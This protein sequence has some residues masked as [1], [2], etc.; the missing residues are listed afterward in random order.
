[1]IVK[2]WIDDVFR[3]AEQHDAAMLATPITSTLKRVDSSQ[4]IVE[5]VS[6]INLWAAQ[7]PQVFRRQLLLDAFA[8]RGDYQPTDEAELVER[9]GYSVKVVTGSPLNLKIT[10]PDDFHMAEHLLEALPKDKLPGLLHP[11]ADEKYD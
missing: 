11:F 2:S 1:M 7:T 5:T 4:S 6:R 3:A 10:S 9:I 8:R